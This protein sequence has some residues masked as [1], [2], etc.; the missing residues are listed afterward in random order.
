ME[1]T[2][3]WNKEMKFTAVTREHR[4]EMDDPTIDRT[5][6][7]GPSPKELVLQGLAGCSAMDV[8]SILE[9]MRQPVESFNVHVSTDLTADHPKVFTNLMMKFELSGELD[10]EK[11]KKAVDYSLTKYCGVA[12]MIDKVTPVKFELYLNGNL[13]ESGQARF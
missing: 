12:A 10:S 3:Y 5:V 8:I 6:Q 1:T 11:C 9:K 2:L 4:V 13:V 7:S